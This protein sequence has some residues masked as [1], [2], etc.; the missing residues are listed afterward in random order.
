MKN[1]TLVPF[2]VAVLS[3]SFALTDENPCSPSDNCTVIATCCHSCNHCTGNT[4]CTCTYVCGGGRASCDCNC[5]GSGYIGAG[6]Q[7]VLSVS[8]TAL[9][10]GFKVGGTGLTLGD[11]GEFLEERLNWN[12]NVD[13]G[14]ATTPV[15]VGGWGSSSI[16]LQAALEAFADDLNVGIAFSD[17]T[18]TITFTAP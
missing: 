11:I 5:L 1:L 16:T 9:N 17:A 12:V 15:P 13:S 7:L 18:K 3:G 10:A 2:I 6:P 4:A 8:L 14:I